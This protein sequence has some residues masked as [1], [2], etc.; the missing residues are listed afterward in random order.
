MQET[1]KYPLCLSR[2][3]GLKNLIKRYRLRKLIKS[4]D[5]DIVCCQETRIRKQDE[6]YIKVTFAGTIY[7][8][9]AEVKK[10]GGGEAIMIGLTKS[11]NWQM[12][13]TVVDSEGQFL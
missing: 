3:A 11:L 7:H 5:C 13:E 2:V 10:L 1:G 8:A 12:H 9:A 6:K 4:T